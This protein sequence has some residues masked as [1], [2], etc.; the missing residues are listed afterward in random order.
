MSVLDGEEIQGISTVSHVS[1]FVLN[2]LVLPVV[3]IIVVTT[4][5]P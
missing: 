4:G 1:T 3:P 2:T 5:L